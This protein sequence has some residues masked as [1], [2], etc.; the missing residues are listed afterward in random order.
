MKLLFLVVCESCT[1]SI[2]EDMPMPLA[3]AKLTAVT[4]GYGMAD[5]DCEYILGDM[6]EKCQCGGHSL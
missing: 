3:D 2:T 5:H 4:V 6:E 1:D